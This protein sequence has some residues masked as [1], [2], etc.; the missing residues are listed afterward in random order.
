LTA[1]RWSDGDWINEPNATTTAVDELVVS[2]QQGSDLW[3]S[4]GSGCLRDSG[5]ALLHPFNRGDV[6][7]VSFVLDFHHHFDQAGVVVRSSPTSWI[8]AGIEIH[9]GVAHVGAVVTSGLSDWSMTPV[10]AWRSSVVTVRIAW[11][12]ASVAVSARSSQAA[13]RPLRL[14]P[15]TAP[16]AGAGPYCA[17]P[18][19]DGLR[20]RFVE[21]RRGGLSATS[22]S[23]R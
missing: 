15:W 5:H 4:R 1:L 11:V 13:W 22:N 2:A 10:P 17:S 9:D 14:A 12:D 20:V 3:R 6:M 16:H 21:W 19:R 7:D 23:S 18:E 8:K